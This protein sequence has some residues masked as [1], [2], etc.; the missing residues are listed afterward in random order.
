MGKRPSEGPSEGDWAIQPVLGYPSLIF[1]TLHFEGVFN[2][3]RTNLSKILNV[4]SS[5]KACRIVQIWPDRISLDNTLHCGL[6]WS[7]KGL[8]GLIYPIR[9]Q[10]RSLTNA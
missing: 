4:P 1:G 7:T 8:F 2:W 10:L 9:G 6:E 5:S 3:T